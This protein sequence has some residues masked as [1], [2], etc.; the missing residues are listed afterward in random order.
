MAI[1][2]KQYFFYQLFF[3]VRT[4]LQGCRKGHHQNGSHQ[5]G[6]CPGAGRPDKTPGGIGFVLIFCFFLI[7]QKEIEE[8]ESPIK[9]LL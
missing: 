5:N 8:G 1:V 4:N 7:K 6:L 2:A 3:S 9:N